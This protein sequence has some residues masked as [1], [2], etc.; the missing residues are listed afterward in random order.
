MATDGER[1]QCESWSGSFGRT[2]R[3]RRRAARC[4]MRRRR[5]EERGQ[6]R[7]PDQLDRSGHQELPADDGARRSGRRCLREGGLE[8]VHLGLEDFRSR[9]LGEARDRGWEGPPSPE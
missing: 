1:S 2:D 8:E 5:R 3:L 7:D 9:L 4:S 6:V